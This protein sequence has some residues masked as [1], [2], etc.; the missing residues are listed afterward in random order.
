MTK[1]MLL[2]DFDRLSPLITARAY[3]G[4]HGA[5]DQVSAAGPESHRFLRYQWFAA[6]LTAYGTA[7]EG[8]ARTLLVLDNGTPTIALPIRG[9]GPRWARL[10]AVPGSYWPFR[11][12]PAAIAADD[13]HFTVLADLLAREVNALRLGPV[14]DDDPAAMALIG[15]ARGRG[16]AV[17]AR[18]IADSFVLDLAVQAAGGWPRTSTLRKNRFHEKH[19]AAHGALEWRFLDGQA[20]VSGGFEALSAIEKASWI[21]DRTDGRDAK[22]TATGHGRFWQQAAQDP[23]LAAMMHAAL[24]TV[25]GAPAAFSFDIDAG[26][27]KYAIANSYDPRFAK[28][29][30]GKLLSYRNLAQGLARGIERVDWGAGDTGYKRVMGAVKGPAINDWL[31]LRPGLPAMLGRLVKLAWAR[32]GQHHSG[33]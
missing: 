13:G 18:H 25:E 22:F 29:S 1:P 2:A 9:V 17:M 15:A 26:P 23:A 4:L 3:E 19:L 10:A 8:A 20:L 21:S 12:F 32:S 33:H 6:A 30:A 31:L 11:S 16:W 7:Y 27:L 24:L 14:Y 28:H 5:I